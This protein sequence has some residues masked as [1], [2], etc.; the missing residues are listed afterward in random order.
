MPVPFVVAAAAVVAGRL[1][2][3]GVLVALGVGIALELLYSAE[4]TH[5]VEEGGPVWPIWVAAGGAPL[6]LLAA[7]VLRRRRA[8]EAASTSWAAAVALAFVAPIAVG[9]LASL[10]RADEP[11]PSAL[12]PGVVRALNDLERDVVVI[13]PVPTAYRAAAFAPVYVVATPPPHAAD[14]DENRPYRRQ[15]DVIRFFAPASGASDEERLRLLDRY[16]A[17][18]LLVDKHRPHPRR[19]IRSLPAVYEDGRYALFRVSDG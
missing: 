5:V 3:A 2:L 15:R 10:D 12:S 4:T 8:P 14:T 9:G 19:L 6:A 18:V 17:D 11:D 7:F 16:G 13:A 1:R